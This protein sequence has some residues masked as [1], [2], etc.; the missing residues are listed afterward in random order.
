MQLVQKTGLNSYRVV[1]FV[2]GIY[3]RQFVPIA[4]NLVESNFRR[5]DAERNPQMLSLN[6]SCWKASSWIYSVSFN[7]QKNFSTEK[8][9]GRSCR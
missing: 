1:G 8:V 6:T 5:R 2:D 3:K 7:V 9:I 4:R